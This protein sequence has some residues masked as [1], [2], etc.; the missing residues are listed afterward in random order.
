MNTNQM[1]MSL[2]GSMSVPEFI[3]VEGWT[4][5]S[6]VVSIP[7]LSEITDPFQEYK[8][9]TDEKINSLESTHKTLEEKTASKM[10]HLEDYIDERISSLDKYLRK[11]MEEKLKEERKIREQVEDEFLVS[12][13]RDREN[14]SKEMRESMRYMM[15]KISSLEKELAEERKSRDSQTQEQETIRDMMGNMEKALLE[16][17]RKLT[18]LEEKT[19]SL[20]EKEEKLNLTQRIKFIEGFIGSRSFNGQPAN[21]SGDQQREYDGEKGE[22]LKNLYCPKCSTGGDPRALIFHHSVIPSIDTNNLMCVRCK[23]V[24]EFDH[25]KVMCDDNKLYRQYCQGKKF[26]YERI[27]MNGRT[28]SLNGEAPTTSNIVRGEKINLSEANL[29]AN[30]PY[31]NGSSYPVSNLINNSFVSSWAENGRGYGNFQIDLKKPVLLSELCIFYAYKGR[32][33][34]NIGSELHIQCCDKKEIVHIHNQNSDLMFRPTCPVWISSFS[35]HSSRKV[36]QE[37]SC[38][39]ISQIE[40][41]GSV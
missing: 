22:M 20:V 28:I 10:V 23:S 24:V 18:A 7:P 35:I 17:S 26:S 37:Q 39:R 4:S 41:Y 33:G 8:R 40:V 11:E 29:T 38:L 25:A 14:I 19:A 34:S 6:P 12:Q 3:E 13:N 15:D 5:P 1:S 32:D 2:S 30:P 16:S 27:E 21:F 36:P 9:A 31:C